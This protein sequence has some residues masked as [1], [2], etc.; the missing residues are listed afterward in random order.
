MFSMFLSYLIHELLTN[1]Y[2]AET[3]L[4]LIFLHRCLLNILFFP[5]NS[6]F[7]FSQLLSKVLVNNV[8]DGNIETRSDEEVS[9]SCM[10]RPT[11]PSSGFPA[12]AVFGIVTKCGSIGT[13]THKK[14]ANF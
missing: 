11:C 5:L 12:F 3:L 13:L 4:F 6:I 9:S 14:H 1:F 8:S 7:Q 2:F 10:L